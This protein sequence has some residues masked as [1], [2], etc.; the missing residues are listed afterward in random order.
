MPLGA[1]DM[2]GK[3]KVRLEAET[4]NSKSMAEWYAMGVGSCMREHKT[5]IWYAMS[6]RVM[7]DKCQGLRRSG[8]FEKGTS[9]NDR[10]NKRDY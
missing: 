2:P 1:L 8:A 9:L 7:V 3:C 10:I 4:Y 6:G 5:G